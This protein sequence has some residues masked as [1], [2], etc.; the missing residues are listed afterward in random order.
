MSEQTTES[1]KIE[2]NRI[3]VINVFPGMKP[4]SLQTIVDTQKAKALILIGHAN[5]GIQ[6]TLIPAVKSIVD[7]GRPVVVLSDNAGAG[8]GVI[9]YSD[10]PQIDAVAAGVTYLEKPNITNLAEV[11]EAI[12]K[13]LDEQLAGKE[14]SEKLKEK[15]AYGPGEKPVSILDD[16]EKR[17]EELDRMTQRTDFEE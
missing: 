13:L 12:R 9:R 4:D 7:S 3:P 17:Q 16:V 15:F 8:H 2:A 1:P 14:L 10:Q 11:S 5:G 6:D